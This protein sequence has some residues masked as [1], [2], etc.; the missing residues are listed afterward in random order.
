MA[1]D[2]WPDELVT[3]VKGVEQLVER[4]TDGGPRALALLDQ[5]GARIR[6]YLDRLGVEVT[7]PDA[8]RA[9]LAFVLL[10]AHRIGSRARVNGCTHVALN[11]R[12]VRNGIVA[13]VLPHCPAEAR[14]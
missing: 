2:A 4:A 11:A 1:T 10:F 3:L 6:D 12:F 13:A 7:D 9:G 8:L 5:D 14:R